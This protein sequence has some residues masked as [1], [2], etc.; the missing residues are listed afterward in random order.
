M[1]NYTRKLTVLL[2]FLV[3]IGG[4]FIFSPLTTTS[5]IKSSPDISNKESFSHTNSS[6]FTINSTSAYLVDG[7]SSSDLNQTFISINGYVSNVSI[8]KNVPLG[9]NNPSFTCISLHPQ[10]SVPKMPDVP[11]AGSTPSVIVFSS[12]LYSS[13]SG[14]L[15]RFLSNHSFLTISSSFYNL[16]A[17]YCYSSWFFIAFIGNILIMLLGRCLRLHSGRS[18]GYVYT[19]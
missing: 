3:M 7:Y 9:I 8:I 15:G 14:S 4:I 11:T 13:I 17:M 12:S 18:P 6:A 16:S 5:P 1:N 19:S 2:F 10:Q